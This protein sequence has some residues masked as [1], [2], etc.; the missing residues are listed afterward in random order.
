MW[1]SWIS[2]E[3]SRICFGKATWKSLLEGPNAIPLDFRCLAR[4]PGEPLLGVR[5]PAGLQGSLLL[6]SL[7]VFGRHR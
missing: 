2:V 1:L 4:R 3:V 5:Y 6:S 7:G